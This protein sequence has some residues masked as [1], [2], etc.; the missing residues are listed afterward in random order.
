[1][2]V[3]LQVEAARKANKKQHVVWEISFVPKAFGSK[4]YHSNEFYMAET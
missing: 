4:D 1:M 3:S 2:P